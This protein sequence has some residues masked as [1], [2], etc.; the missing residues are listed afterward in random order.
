MKDS[1]KS[2]AGSVFKKEI[3]AAQNINN[4]NNNAN[5]RNGAFGKPS[6]LNHR[7]AFK[8]IGGLNCPLLTTYAQSYKGGVCA[9]GIG[10]RNVPSAPERVLDAPGMMDDFYLNLLDWGKRN[11][12]GV[13]LASSVY[14]WSGRDASVHELMTLPDGS[15]PIDPYISSLRWIHDGTSMGI[16]TSEGQV[17]IWDIEAGKRIRTILA[18]A[19]GHR[20]GSLAWNKHLLSTGSRSGKVLTHDVRLAKPLIIRHESLHTQEICGLEWSPDGKQL[21]SGANDNLVHLWDVDSG[22]PRHVLTEHKSAVKAI[23]WCPWKPGLLATGGG[24]QDRQIRTWNAIAGEC[25]STVHAGS[26]V[27]SL[28]WSRTSRELVS[29][30]GHSRNHVRFWK[31]KPSS[32]SP[33]QLMAAADIEEAHQSRILHMTLSPDGQTLVSAGADESIKFWKAFEREDEMPTVSGKQRKTNVKTLAAS[34]GYVLMPTFSRS[35][36]VSKALNMSNISC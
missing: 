13:G 5:S 30:H 35:S 6:D 26:T 18:S 32:T 20:I 34:S 31:Q 3:S 22:T 1:G 7:Q 19:E 2:F 17:Q 21:A 4:N 25:L 10:S 11:I 15:G 28:V 36:A 14:L 16:G 9:S 12:L 23:A 29:A 24:S 8:A 33:C 27:S